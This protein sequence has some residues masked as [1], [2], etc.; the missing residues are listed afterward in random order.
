[1][2]GEMVLVSLGGTAAGAGYVLI[3]F[4]CGV[5]STCYACDDCAAHSGQ[6]WF[7]LPLEP[8]TAVHTYL[9][10][11][12]SFAVATCISGCATITDLA[13]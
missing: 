1:M 3:C 7:P 4:Y 13:K 11:V 5:D 6:T 2:N 8:S 9:C 10:L 12:I